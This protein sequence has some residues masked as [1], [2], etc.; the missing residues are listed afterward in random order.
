[1]IPIYDVDR[2]APEVLGLQDI[3]SEIDQAKV[4]RADYSKIDTSLWD[5]QA[6]HCSNVDY[7][8][9][10]NF[11]VV[12]TDDRRLKGDKEVLISVLRTISHRIAT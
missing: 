12:N 6:A 11:K 2:L 7:P 1:M 8:E 3:Y 10:F 5:E 4:A 9:D